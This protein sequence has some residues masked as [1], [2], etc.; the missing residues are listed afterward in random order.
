MRVPLRLTLAAL[1]VSAVESLLLA[2]CTA[3]NSG[4]TS[5]PMPAPDSS[6]SAAPSTTTVPATATSLPTTTTTSTTVPPTVEVV[7]AT[8]WQLQEGD[9]LVADRDGVR[10]YRDGAEVSIPVSSPTRVA[11]ADGLGG[12]VLQPVEADPP[13][14]EYLP[15]GALELW[16][17]TP[18]GQAALLYRSD[19]DRYRTDR[20][21]LFDVV[22]VEPLSQAP[23]VLF[24]ETRC[25]G[26]PDPY[27]H[28]QDVL[29]ALPLDACGEPVVITAPVGSWEGGIGGVAWQPGPGRFLISMAAEGLY[30]MSA[31][32]VQGNE[33]AWP[34]N[35][36]P[37]NPAGEGAIIFSMAAAKGQDEIVYARSPTP[38]LMGAEA[39]DLVLYDTTAGREAAR[40]TIAAQPTGLHAGTLRIAVSSTGWTQDQGQFYEP[41]GIIELTTGRVE[42]PGFQGRASIVTELCCSPP[43]CGLP[44]QD[45]A[46]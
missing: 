26:D 4:E 36:N 42:Y 38:D 18:D 12:I 3:G 25:L 16:R 23:S 27:C 15:R 37:W 39:L 46:G 34:Q 45:G 44:T 43:V 22:F 28:P 40:L 5:G 11:I 21:E 7:A 30:W 33:V 13:A 31:W 32:D 14:S 17:V 29:L 1:L 2:G 8:G 6:T 24:T 35:P 19:P 20:L 9:V 41:V 10:Q